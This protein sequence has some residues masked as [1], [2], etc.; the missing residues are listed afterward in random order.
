M[1]VGFIQWPEL[2]TEAQDIASQITL[3][4]SSQEARV[5]GQ[6]I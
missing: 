6:D 3:R 2:R 5:E 4:D 1:R